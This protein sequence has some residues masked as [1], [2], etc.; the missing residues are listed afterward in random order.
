MTH[1]EV[2]QAASVLRSQGRR[3]IEI[4]VNEGIDEGGES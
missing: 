1:D 2:K 4:L 3:G